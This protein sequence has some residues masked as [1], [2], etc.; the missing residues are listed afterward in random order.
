MK[1]N[2]NRQYKEEGHEVA[3]KAPAKRAHT[4]QNIHTHNPYP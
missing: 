4:S 3:D 2:D 1:E